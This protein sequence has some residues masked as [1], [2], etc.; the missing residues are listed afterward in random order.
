MLQGIDPSSTDSLT[1]SITDSLRLE[2]DRSLALA[3]YDIMCFAAQ[4][5]TNVM[6]MAIVLLSL[7]GLAACTDGEW[8][9]GEWKD[10]ENM[11]RGSA[12]CS[13][14]CQG[15]QSE[16]QGGCVEAP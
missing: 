14:P 11:C 8:R 9:A 15:G 4:H 7:I 16:S 12:S 13:A 5:G 6:I 3:Y 1:Y 10:M 2:F